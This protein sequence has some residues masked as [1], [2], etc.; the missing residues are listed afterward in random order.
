MRHLRYFLAVADAGNFSRA[1]ERLHLAQP[2]L[3]QTVRRVEHT[4]GVRLFDRHPH[5]ARLTADGEALVA[6]TT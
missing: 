1:A 3:S 4:L 6:A 2:A 5:G